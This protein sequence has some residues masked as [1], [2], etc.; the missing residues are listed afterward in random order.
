MKPKKKNL[1]S[2]CPVLI[3]LIVCS[4]C[5][6]PGSGKIED[7]SDITINPIGDHAVGDI[8]NI[9]GTTNFPVN[10]TLWIQ[11]GP[12][13]YTKYPPHYIGERVQVVQGTNS[14]LWSIQINTSTFAIDEYSILI[15]PLNQGPVV[16]GQARFNMT[17]RH[18]GTLQATSV[19]S[20]TIPR[21]SP[22]PQPH[23]VTFLNGTSR[24]TT[25]APLSVVVPISAL[26]ICCFFGRLYSKT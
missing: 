25:S 5:I 18:T 12:K 23:E 13:E 16:L 26:A 19:P 14:N 21:D 9:S 10:T 6:C 2:I 4:L 7:S 11:A 8:I 22:S 24:P 20:T 3:L 1:T 15:S 17:A